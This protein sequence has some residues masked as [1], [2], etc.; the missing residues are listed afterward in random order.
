[1]KACLMISPSVSQTHPRFRALPDLAVREMEAS[2]AAAPLLSNFG[3]VVSLDELRAGDVVHFIRARFVGTDPDLHCRYEKSVGH[4]N[5][6]GVIAGITT[7]EEG[8]K[9]VEVLEQNPTPVQRGEYYL[10]DHCGGEL[11]FYRAAT[12]GCAIEFPSGTIVPSV[13]KKKKRR[14]RQKRRRLAKA[15]RARLSSFSDPNPLA[16]LLSPPLVVAALSCD[17]G[18]ASGD[19]RS[20]F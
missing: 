15:G 9:T 2:G 13:P 16:N 12:K 19:L 17:R 6:Y 4:P 18:A 8:R 10:S 1:M 5:H 11:N 3:A 7:D 14:G 20:R